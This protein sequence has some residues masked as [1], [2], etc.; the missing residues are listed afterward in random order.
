MFSALFMNKKKMKF[1]WTCLKLFFLMR[2]LLFHIVLKLKEIISTYKIIIC[3]YYYLLILMCVNNLIIF[4]YYS[5]VLKNSLSKS[6]HKIDFEEVIFWIKITSLKENVFQQTSRILYNSRVK[7]F[8]NTNDSVNQ[9][10]YV[11][12]IDNVH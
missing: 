11:N 9:L 8:K 3:A 10:E 6:F 4:V 5:L 7:M 2:N 1:K 12:I